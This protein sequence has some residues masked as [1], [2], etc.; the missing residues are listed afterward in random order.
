[1]EAHG[2]FHS[3]HCIKCNKEYSQDWIREK[4]FSDEIPKCESC[5][6]VVKPDIVFFGEALP[7]R[8]FSCVQSDFKQC[9][10]LIIM[11]SS[12]LVQPFA[13]LIDQ[14]SDVCPRLLINKEKAGIV[15]DL[16]RLLMG[17]GLQY[18][19]PGNYRDVYQEGD[20]DSVS[21]L[22]SEKLGWQA[23]LQK[24]REAVNKS[25]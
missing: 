2:T 7:A 10:L 14:V 4:I 6:G 19:N 20:T 13:S 17:E 9:D 1:V 8:F 22:I 11:G 21:Q 25:K 12:L 3:A 5:Q 24:L 18:E 23:D 16:P 15:K